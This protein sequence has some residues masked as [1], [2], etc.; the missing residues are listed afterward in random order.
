MVFCSWST[1]TL[2]TSSATSIRRSRL[3][4]RSSR[5]SPRT[6]PSRGLT[7]LLKIVVSGNITLA[8][9]TGFG[10]SD[11][12]STRASATAML[13]RSAITARLCSMASATACSIVNDTGA[14]TCA[15][16]AAARSTHAAASR[17]PTP[18]MNPPECGFGDPHD[19]L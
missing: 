18:H 4:P 8:V 19:K 17:T 10:R 15:R 12:V 6:I 5:T 14:C 3:P 7:L 1:V 16:A 13:Y 2:R 11:A 9:T